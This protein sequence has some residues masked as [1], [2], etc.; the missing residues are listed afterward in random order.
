MPQQFVVR[1]EVVRRVAPDFTYDNIEFSVTEYIAL[2]ATSCAC[3]CNANSAFYC[4]F[5][6]ASNTLFRE[7]IPS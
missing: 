4:A 2:S 3:K 5:L 1:T 6:E 7:F